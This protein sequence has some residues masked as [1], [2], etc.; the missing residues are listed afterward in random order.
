MS[1]SPSAPRTAPCD[2]PAGPQRFE[3]HVGAYGLGK[4]LS[5]LLI[6]REGFTLDAPPALFRQLPGFPQQGADLPAIS[7]NLAFG[8]QPG[9]LVELFFVQLVLQ[10]APEASQRR[11]VNAVGIEQLAGFLVADAVTPA[12]AAV[13]PGDGAF[14]EELLFQFLDL[15]FADAEIERGLVSD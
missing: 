7:R 3:V 9:F 5:P 13:V 14:I 10:R 12:I 4:R 2:Q 8:F 6:G 1:G 11:Q 15:T